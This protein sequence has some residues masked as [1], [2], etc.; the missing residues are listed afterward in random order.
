M[1]C[2]HGIVDNSCV[3]CAIERGTDRVV[4]AI[5]A[6]LKPWN[7]TDLPDRPMGVKQPGNIYAGKCLKSYEPGLWY[8]YV[9]LSRDKDRWL[10]AMF[11]SGALGAQVEEFTDEEIDKLGYVGHIT[12]GL[13]CSRKD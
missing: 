3:P 9:L 13:S 10:V 8:C 5:E 4:A 11:N 2:R 7:A 1:K 12:E 6:T